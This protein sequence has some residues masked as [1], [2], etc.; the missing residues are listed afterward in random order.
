[1]YFQ[2]RSIGFLKTTASWFLAVSCTPPI[3]TAGGLSS[4][5]GK[6]IFYINI[7]DECGGSLLREPESIGVRNALACLGECLIRDS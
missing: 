5:A 6:A 1:M 3:K 4:T 2:T 7:V